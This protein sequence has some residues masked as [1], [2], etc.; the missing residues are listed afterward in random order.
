[1]AMPR[2]Q[3]Q[4]V[5]IKILLPRGSPGLIERPRLI[6]LLPQ[7][8]TRHVV[9]DEAGPGFGKT[10]LAIT[11]A[12]DLQQAGHSVPWLALN[13]DENEPTRFKF[14][15]ACVLQTACNGIGA[16]VVDMISDISLAPP[17]KLHMQLFAMICRDLADLAR[18]A[19]PALQ[20]SGHATASDIPV[21]SA[22]A[23]KEVPIR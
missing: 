21:R 5:A 15:V 12:E 2:R 17:K 20:C 8:E 22:R 16:A 10:S 7:V 4:I 6:G 13:P 9:V 18:L 11:W 1:M 23:N 14:Y 3:P 19:P